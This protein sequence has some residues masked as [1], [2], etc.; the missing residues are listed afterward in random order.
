MVDDVLPIRAIGEQV[1]EMTEETT[2]EQPSNGW[3]RQSTRAVHR[4]ADT[5]EMDKKAAGFGTAQVDYIYEQP[6]AVLFRDLL[7]PL[8]LYPVVSGH[9]G[10]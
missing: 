7:P 6:P 9:A 1:H 10:I 2:E 8:Y 4:G 3:K 5:A